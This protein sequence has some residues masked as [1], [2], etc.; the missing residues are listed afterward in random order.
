MRPVF[1][2]ATQFSS[3]VSTSSFELVAPRYLIPSPETTQLSGWILH[4]AFP[5]K[6]DVQAASEIAGLTGL[7]EQ[8][9]KGSKISQRDLRLEPDIQ[10]ER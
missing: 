9:V 6:V 10:K 3:F 8:F 4:V 7:L 1:I 2:E 5:G